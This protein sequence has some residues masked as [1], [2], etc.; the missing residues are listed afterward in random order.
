MTRP[1][2]VLDL[3]GLDALWPGAGLYRYA[4]DVVRE[5]ADLAPPAVFVVLGHSPQPVPDLAPAFTGRGWEYRHFPRDGGRGSAYLDHLRMARTLAD[6]RADLCHCLHSFAPAF[7]PCPVV[8]TL[9]DMMFELFPEYHQAVASRPY[10]IYRWVVRRR[11][12]RVICP[13]RTSADDLR[14][15]WGVPER[16][17]RVVP[18]GIRAFEPGMLTVV[19]ENPTLRGLP[20]GRLISSP[21]NLEPRKNLR[22][23]LAAYTGVRTRFSDIPLVLYGRGG[24]AEGREREYRQELERLGLTEAVVEPGVLTDAELW[25]LYRRSALFVFPSLYEGFGYPVVEAMA[26]GVCPV[27]RGCS[28][29]A[30]LVGPAGVQVEPFT[31]ES[32]AAAMVELLED[33][34]RR[35]A[36]AAAAAERAREYTARRMAQG[37]FDVYTQLLRA[38]C[39]R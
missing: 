15:L 18:H 11:V 4:V 28:S 22:T 31:S 23:L 37:T 2:I 14:R 5:L 8:V 39:S 25:W 35:A 27:V 10:R 12:R 26:A 36:L 1:R 9:Q 30:E 17:I 7:S 13:S 20:A 6:V 32:L 21:L 3:G 16:R 24:L 33:A 38:R 29:M 34:P 19:P